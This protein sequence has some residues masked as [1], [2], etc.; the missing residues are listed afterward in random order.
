MIEPPG[1]RGPSSR[2]RS[3]GYTL[4]ELLV[5]VGIL[6][7]IGTLLVGILKSGLDMWDRG[8]T[9]RD[10]VER[11]QVVMGEFAREIPRAF[12]DMDS[13]PP[14][15][16]ERPVNIVVDPAAATAPGSPARPGLFC[17]FD[18][19]GRQRLRL[20]RA[21]VVVLSAPPAGG[22]SEANGRPPADDPKTSKGAGSG[23]DEEGDG[24][25]LVDYSAWTDELR[26]FSDV[27]FVLH[28]SPEGGERLWRV[29][30]DTPAQGET[31]FPDVPF[32]SEAELAQAG[33]AVV[34][35]GVLYL[36]YRFWCHTTS[37][38]DT[39]KPPARDGASGGPEV[40]WDSTRRILPE[41]TFYLDRSSRLTPPPDV[42][43]ALVQVE[44]DIQP[45]TRKKTWASLRADLDT[46]ATTIEV[47]ST[48][49]FP[50]APGHVRIGDEWISYKEISRSRI[51]VD[52]RGARET[53]PQAH[54]KEA[55]VLWGESFLATFSVR[56]H[57]P[58]RAGTLP[59]AG[60]K[61][62]GKG[63]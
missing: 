46:A 61:K 30:L 19:Q 1:M 28:P 27:A 43:P 2:A 9:R 42:L 12:C 38:W 51:V 45:D 39:A 49:G 22:D 37:T 60:G 63:S 62:K 11:A 54:K 15:L 50:D 41:F 47:D 53:K 23:K 57:R 7:L 34:A 20:S 35:S 59:D 44:L 8:E 6:A 48:L 32:A 25:P 29:F 17:D 26:T 18:P 52:K 14:A 16:T 3:R 13:R 10:V 40:L 55:R 33:G 31:P 21:G 24:P 58:P 56:N 36:R 4:T 5:S